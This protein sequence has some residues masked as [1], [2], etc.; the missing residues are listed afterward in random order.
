MVA[1]LVRRQA[2][3]A[4]DYNRIKVLPIT[5]SIGAEVADVDLREVDDETVAEL[6][7]AWMVHKVLFYRDQDLTREQHIAFGRRFGE[8]EIHPFAPSPPGY[9]E[10]IQLVS[11]AEQFNAAEN[12]HSD[13]MF[14]PEP[15]LGSILRALQLPPYGGDTVWANM[16]MS[17]ENLPDDVKERIE[18]KLAINSFVKVFGRN[19]DAEKRAQRLAEYP[20][21]AHPMVRTHPVTG[22]KTLYCCGPFTDRI[23]GMDR[24]ESDALL[25]YL[26]AR[27]AIPEYQVRFRWYPGSLAQWDNRCTQHYAVPDYRGF[28]RHMERV[29]ILG[30]RPF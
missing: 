7:A 29:T 8:L 14:Q 27:T 26:F 6:R 15:P 1:T 13:V 3:Q 16:E 18:G 17:Y 2:V 24:A 19:L 30:D 25:E 28:N 21:V 12:W 5:G 20:E 22:E 23:E 4:K 9:P 11:T 10:L